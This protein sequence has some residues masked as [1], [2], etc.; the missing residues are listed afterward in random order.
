MR[1]IL[2]STLILLTNIVQSSEYIIRTKETGFYKISKNEIDKL[3]L[4]KSNISLGDVTINS[5]TGERPYFFSSGKSRLKQ[6]DNLIFFA[7]TLKGEHTKQHLHDDDNGFRL[8]ESKNKSN[9]KHWIYKTDSIE[10]LP[11]CK[12]TFISDHYEA[13]KLLIRVTQ[14]EYKTTP[15][16]WYWKKLNYLLK[17]G[18]SIPFDVSKSNGKSDLFLTTA[19]RSRN[20]DKRATDIPHHNIQIL[21]NGVLIN[22]LQWDGK[23][24]YVSDKLIIPKDLLNADNNTI[25]FKVPKRKIDKKAIIDLTMLDY[26][27]IDFEADLSK[28]TASD[29]LTSDETC[30]VILKKNQFA[31]SE[32]NKMFAFDSVEVTPNSR[33]FIGNEDKIKNPG[34]K[35]YSPIDSDLSETEYLMITH[36]LFKD[37]LKTL[38]EF[39]NNKGIKSTIVDTDQI[40]QKYSFGVRELY[41]IKDLIKETHT[42]S[43]GQLKYVLLVG[44]S[45]WDWRDYGKQNQYG[46]WA[47]RLIGNNRNF[48]NFPH[49]ESYTEEYSNRDF[50]PTGQF[51]SSEGHS[52][53]DNWFV[54]IVP[55]EN[56]KG[57]DFIPDLAVGRF[58]VSTPDELDAM[59]SKTIHYT[60]NTKV[61]PWKSRVLWITNSN[62]RYQARSVRNSNILGE[63][64]VSAHNIFP[65]VMDGDNFKVQE[66]LSNSFDEGNLIVHFMGHGGKSIWRIGPPDIKKNRD[67][68]TLDHISKLNNS[69]TLPFVMS[70]SCYSAPFDHPYADSIGEK[71]IREPKVGAI[72]VLAASWRNT[73][74]DIFSR[75]IL[76]GIYKNPD[77]SIGQAVLAGKRH[78]KG[79]TMVE[80]YNLLGDP[81]VHLALPTLKMISTLSG[82]EMKANIDTKAFKGKAK[83]ELLDIDSTVL[84]SNEITVANTDF[85]FK[86][87]KIPTECFQGRIYAWDSKQNIDAMSSFSCTTPE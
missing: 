12:K 33:I 44:D 43:N 36:P 45:S 10:G 23:I 63:Y 61:G 18:F 26:F 64:G 40:Y 54:S 46:N 25:T 75:Y 73:P 48:T 70:M 38:A 31:Y 87:E 50:V 37:S 14:Q 16:L 85:N 58:P 79:R 39:Y 66:T 47:S 20:I 68:F 32:T 21:I 24:Q 5:A 41:S 8:S 69:N 56:Q 59:V 67:L 11:V 30:K 2:T 6:N 1:F 4:H 78:F 60:N 65:K 7:E 74:K 84:S 81:A 55:E 9:K 13:N 52:A 29:S 86:F 72:A 34:I 82:N 35:K 22:S 17:D 76:E 83:I 28:I 15:E 27:K 53:S 3:G 62:K 57:E 77:F 42:K 19:F 51:H 49:Q 80:M 71:F